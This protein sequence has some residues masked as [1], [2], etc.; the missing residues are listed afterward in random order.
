MEL[1]PSATSRKLNRKPF[2]TLITLS[3]IATAIT[4]YSHFFG[5]SYLK[6]QLAAIG[7]GNAVISLSLDESLRQSTFALTTFINSVSSTAPFKAILF[8]AI[9]SSAL[10]F[11]YALV[12]EKEVLPFTIRNR[13]SSAIL[14]ARKHL[15]KI[16][17]TMAAA[18]GFAIPYFAFSLLIVLISYSWVLLSM[19]EQLGI[20][21]MS[22]KI[23]SGPCSTYDQIS[24]EPGSPSFYQGCTYLKTNDGEEFIGVLI[25]SDEERAYYLSNDRAIEVDTERNVIPYTPILKAPKEL[26]TKSDDPATKIETLPQAEA[27][28]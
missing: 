22:L 6:G 12:S 13:V 9:A 28:K 1:N 23:E 14:S 17:L 27:D 26:T 4:T 15:S 21:N 3:A 19:G 25:Y 7:Y 24:W 5:Y 18:I 16:Q 20:K 10:V 8:P 11:L 2:R